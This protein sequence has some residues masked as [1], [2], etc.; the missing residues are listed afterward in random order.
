MRSNGAYAHAPEWYRNFLYAEERA[1]GLDFSEDL[2]SPG[3]CRFDLSRERGGLADGGRGAREPLSAPARRRAPSRRSAPPSARGAPL[4]RPARA[5]GR[6]V[7][8]AARRGPDRRRRLPVV[9][10]LGPGHLHLAARPVPRDGTSRRGRADPRRVGGRGLGGDAAQP[11]SRTEKSA[12]VQLG[13]RVAL[14]PRRRAR[15]LPGASRCRPPRRRL[16]S[17]GAPERLRRDPDGLRARHALRDPRRRGRPARRG[18]ARRAAHLDGREGRRLGRHAA[19]RQARRDPGPLD[20]RAEDRRGF[21]ATSATCSRRRTASF[22]RRFWN[23]EAGCL[24]DVVDVDHRP[25]TADPTLRPNQIFAV[26]GLPFPLLD[27]RAARRVVDAVEEKLWTPLGLRTLAPGHPDYHAALRRRAARARR[28]LPPGH[29]LAVAPRARSSRPGSACGAARRRRSARRGSASWRRSSP[30]STRPASAT[31]PRSP[32]ATRPTPRAAARS[33]P[34]RWARSCGSIAWFFR[35]RPSPDAASQ[36]A[37][38]RRP[39]RG[40]KV[41]T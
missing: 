25:G 33:R 38:T 17:D 14:V 16:R 21:T 27:G 4:P 24:Y 3:P 9:H 7:S 6:R 11:V 31:S 35:S 32:T 23:E 10:R 37:A 13:R 40:S 1:R 30:T 12:R 39:G 19:D 28:R 26:G 5:L 15:V 18:R 34:G 8:R 2:A 41:R 20:Q 36:A 22:E 29:G